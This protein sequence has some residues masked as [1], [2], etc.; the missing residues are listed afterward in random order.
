M[1]TN[2]VLKLYPF[3]GEQLMKMLNENEERLPRRRAPEL[4]E[5]FALFRLP[6]RRKMEIF[7]EKEATVSIVI[8]WIDPRIFMEIEIKKPETM[9]WSLK[10]K[11]I[12][13]TWKVLESPMTMTKLLDGAMLLNQVP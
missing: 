6:D 7:F 10:E 1:E 12:V 3:I 8:N 9:E 11:D 5:K 4:D 2:D 13:L